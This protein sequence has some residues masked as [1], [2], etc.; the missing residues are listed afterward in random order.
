MTVP[1]G[2]DLRG[3]VLPTTSWALAPQDCC[4]SSSHEGCCWLQLEEGYSRARR[5]VTKH[6]FQPRPVLL[7]WFPCLRPIGYLRQVRPEIQGACHPEQG[8]RPIPRRYLPGTTS[9]STPVRPHYG[10]HPRG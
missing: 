4:R 6:Y 3:R 9:F 1:S 2:M 5:Q 8:R 7:C 10:L